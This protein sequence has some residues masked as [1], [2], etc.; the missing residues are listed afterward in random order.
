MM[1]SHEAYAEGYGRSQL[2]IDGGW[3]DGSRR[4][5][6]EVIDPT[7]EQVLGVLPVADED[8]VTRAIEA[9]TRAFESWKAVS[10]LERSGLIRSAAEW[11][12]VRRG[13]W[14]T[15]ISLELGKP[16]RQALVE[17]QT[18]CEIL[19][20][21]A[22]EARRQY[23]R[24]IPA[25]SADMR[26]TTVGEP[27]G[28]V[29]AISGW[30]APALT[31]ARKIGYA[32]AA[33]CTI[34]LK[35]SEATPASALMIA[36]AFEAAGLPAGVLNVIFGD[37][38]AIGRRFATDPGIRALSFTG[39]TAVGK[40]LYALCAGTV[41]RMVLELGGH[42]PVIVFADSDVVSVAK[43]AVQ[44][45][46]RNSGQV[47][48]SPTRFLVEA[49][50]YELF[51]RTF[52]AELDGLGVGDPF[53]DGIA[54]GPLQNR[55]RVEA[56]ESLIADAASRGAKVHSGRAPDGPGHW[57]APTVLTDVAAGTRALTEEPFGPLAIITPFD[58]MDD[59]VNEANRLSVGLAAYAFTSNLWRSEHLARSIQAGSLAINH[60]AASFAETPF[61]G[62]RESGLGLEGGSEGVAA[63]RQNRFV[64][65]ASG[66]PAPGG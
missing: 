4:G 64:S 22:E 60:W 42:A 31:P 10:A 18:A 34:V 40:E 20:W 7:T 23:D 1:Q 16:Y 27:L 26:L 2:F 24:V 56:M 58:T 59:A 39:G 55:H 52:L 36:R 25:R 30:N 15:M 61:G 13:D 47:C 37:P 48:T 28:P 57:H 45:K 14:A 21:S 53:V 44:A 49:D 29:G 41:K 43:A 17:T 46:Y 38:P 12:R 62:V 63:F 9:A 54:M 8:D 19:D 32:L 5:T 33:G 3:V 6:T 66:E 35:P 51:T 65:V 11:L 50:A